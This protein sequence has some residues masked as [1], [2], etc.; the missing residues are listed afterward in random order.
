MHKILILRSDEDINY[1]KELIKGLQG[2]VRTK[3]AVFF[4]L[5]TVPIGDDIEKT[6]LNYCSDATHA[7]TLLSINLD[8]SIL[9]LLDKLKEENIINIGI[10]VSYVDDDFK[11]EFRKRMHGIVPVNPISA[12]ENYS[13]AMADVMNYIRIWLKSNKQ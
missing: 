10:Y 3:E 11:E 8:L 13:E 6:F 7:V 12:F 1:S 4:S 2:L 9:D 5:D